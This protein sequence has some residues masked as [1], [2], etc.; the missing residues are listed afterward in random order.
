MREL[1]IKLGNGT[2]LLAVTTLGT[3]RPGLLAELTGVLARDNVNI[4]DVRLNVLH[5]LHTMFLLAEVPQGRW[6]RTKQRLRARAKEISLEINFEHARPHQHIPE[7]IYVVTVMAQDRPGIVSSVAHELAKTG[8]NI[9]RTK[10]I[11]RGELCVLELVVDLDEHPISEIKRKIKKACE[12]IGADAVLQ[13]EDIFRKRKRLA[14]FDLDTTLINAEIINEMA[15]RAGVLD[16][17]GALTESGLQG[18]IEFKDGLRE[19]VSLLKGLHTNELDK[20]A[21]SI[22]LNPGAKDLIL[23]L[24]EMGY[25]LCLLTGSFTYFTDKIKERLGFDYVFANELEIKR[26]RLTGNLRGQ[27][28]DREYKASMLNWVAEQE[29][30]RKEEIV[31][32]GDGSN[33]V[34]MIENAG[35]GIAFKGKEKLK[36]VADG[37]ISGLGGLLY[38][39]GMT[40]KD[41]GRIKKWNSN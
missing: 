7:N 14:V 16:K 15:A 2:K 21:E 36:S 30:I 19:R 4:V 29:G 25:T 31:A 6:G 27:I 39:L 40:D 34:G 17:V 37:T 11:A 9:E 22:E 1:T 32:I 35:L 28:V 18:E 20:V 12:R 26:G 33:D 3:D 5:G 10:M 41:I 8:V 24:K 23:T 38:C 13:P